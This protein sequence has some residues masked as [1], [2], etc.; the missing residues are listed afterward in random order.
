MKKYRE[1]LN[2]TDAENLAEDWEKVTEDLWKVFKDMKPKINTLDISNVESKNLDKSKPILQFQDSD[3]VIENICN[4]EGLEDGLS[5]MKKVFDDSN[6]EKHYYSRVVDHDE[7][8]WIDY[9]S[10]HCFFRVTKGDK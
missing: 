9:G 3:G 8:Y 10:H 2:K 4:V 7:Y 1:Y 5:K 6:F